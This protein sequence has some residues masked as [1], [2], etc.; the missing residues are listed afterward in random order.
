V[1]WS[2]ELLF[3]SDITSHSQL[4]LKE[5][6]VELSRRASLVIVQ[7][8]WRG[9]ALAEENGLDPRRFVFVPNAPSG[10]ARRLPGDYLRR[11]LGLP[12]ERKIVLCSGAFA[13]WAASLDLVEAAEDWPE[14]FFLVMQSRQSLSGWQSD[15]V[16]R[17]RRAMHPDHGAIMSDPVPS[18]GFRGLV[19][20]ADIG[21]AL[22]DPSG[23]DPGGSI[24]HNIEL[25]G[26]A[27]GK[28]ANYL[29]SGL[30][31]VTSDLVGLRDLVQSTGCGE[32]VRSAAEVGTALTAILD[33]YD[34]Y[35]DN[36]CTAF[37]ENL[38]LEGPMEEA[39]ARI[40]TLCEERS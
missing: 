18:S 6:E 29:H 22:Y 3:W 13:P 4:R 15:Y 40:A 24:D 25:M 19:D 21:I 26:F 30:P 38:R 7:D 23:G 2:L 9:H 31:I 10:R 17:V 33:D 35:V 27:S 32:S 34:R 20:S 1:F 39:I 14:R 8:Q 5:R 28:V 37:D 16:G 11:Q 12:E 36:A